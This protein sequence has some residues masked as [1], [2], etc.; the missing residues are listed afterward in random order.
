[1]GIF[2]LN[3]LVGCSNQDNDQGFLSVKKKKG[4]CQWVR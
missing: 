4:D 3:E 2:E 1:M